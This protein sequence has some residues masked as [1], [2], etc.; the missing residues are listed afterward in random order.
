M[1][2]Q[3]HI[4]NY[5]LA[6]ELVVEFTEGFNVLSG[7]T[8]SGKSVIIGA[9]NLVLGEKGDVEFIRTGAEETV[10]SAVI[11]VADNPDAKT[12]LSEHEVQPDDGQI[13][14]RRTL[15]K[16]GR[17]NMYIQ[18]VPFTKTDLSEF[19]SLLFDIHGQHQHQS[20]LSVDNQ[21]RLLDSFGGLTPA[22]EKLKTD[23]IE[24]NLIKKEYQKLIEAE[25]EI[26]READIA[27]FAVREIEGAR[28]KKGE[29]SELE[30]EHKLLSQSEKLFSYI[31]D[32]H[33]N[34]NEGS[35]GALNGIRNALKGLQGLKNLDTFFEESFSRM[36]SVFYEAEDVLASVEKFRDQI[37]FSPERFAA[38]EERLA[39]LL[40][41]R[42]KYGD[43]EEEVMSFL[44]ESRRKVEG[45]ENREELKSEYAEKIKRLEKGVLDQA[46]ALSE[47][48]KLQAQKLQTE[49]KKQL[50]QLGMPKADF[51]VA[52]EK[53]TGENG[54]LSCGVNGFDTVEFLISPNQGEPVKKLKTIASG[55][56]IS[57]VMLAIKS[58]LAENDHVNSLVFDEIDSGIGG[59]I[60]VAVG[61]H[62]YNLSKYKQI[63]CITH[64]ASIAVR[65]DNHIRV[66]KISE[67]GRTLTEIEILDSGTRKVEIAR[68]LSGDTGADVS[69]KHAEE[70]LANAARNPGG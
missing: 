41:L 39:E 20:L 67:G 35:G 22:A 26:L 30:H 62:M 49:I 50:K 24:L 70:L 11:D 18:S 40:R 37:D 12:W 51:K 63:L 36:E 46:S 66:N 2:E 31:E 10:V 68:M 69:L 17:G 15:K 53:K 3:L 33:E 34:L 9:L 8:G 38:C 58:V 5:A 61:E 48:R 25:R 29:F 44:E 65:A 4:K 55:G 19:T 1:L 57:R 42:K 45:I 59:E 64:L 56:E 60:A 23:F 14:I 6:E 32:V 13:I 28:I 16:N 21:R 27:A 54:R 52:V 43:S 7:E 47:N